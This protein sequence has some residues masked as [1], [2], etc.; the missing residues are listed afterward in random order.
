MTRKSP[1]SLGL[2]RWMAQRLRALAVLAKD[3]SLVPSTH[4]VADKHL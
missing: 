4:M 3:L 1:I 2:E